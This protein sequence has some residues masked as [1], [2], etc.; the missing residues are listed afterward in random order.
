MSAEQVAAALN[1]DIAALRKMQ[2]Y[3]EFHQR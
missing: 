3:Q 1:M 2:K